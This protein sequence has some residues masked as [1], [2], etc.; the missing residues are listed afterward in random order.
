MTG[1][2]LSNTQPGVS[3]PHEIHLSESLF[4]SNCMNSSCR[5]SSQQLRRLNCHNQPA[6]RS[7]PWRR[8]ERPPAQAEFRN[9]VTVATRHGT[10]GKRSWELPGRGVL[11]DN[12]WPSNKIEFFVQRGA[13]QRQGHRS[14]QS[15]LEAAPANTPGTGACIT[16]GTG[17]LVIT[18]APVPRR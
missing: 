14:E 10:T 8:S 18:R 16:R 7:S 12:I 4:F 6:S 2:F 1:V 3:W 9:S 15:T 17:V 13:R 11:S 5:H